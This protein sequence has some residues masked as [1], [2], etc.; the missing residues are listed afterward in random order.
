MHRLVGWFVVE[1]DRS[2]RTRRGYRRPLILD[3]DILIERTISG[4]EHVAASKIEVVEKVFI[5]IRQEL[6]LLV[7]VH[8]CRLFEGW[9]W[10]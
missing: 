5:L 1:I 3:L 9:A 4:V 2:S 8:R 7:H 10:L 6:R